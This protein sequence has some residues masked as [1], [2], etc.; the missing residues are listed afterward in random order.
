MPRNRFS[1]AWPPT[2]GGIVIL[3]VTAAIVCAS[4]Q[5]SIA[6][7]PTDTREQGMHVSEY[8]ARLPKVGREVDRSRRVRLSWLR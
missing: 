8:F 7:G 2:S 3:G 6:H 1:E 4:T 5:P